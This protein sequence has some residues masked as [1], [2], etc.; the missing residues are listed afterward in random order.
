[1][2]NSL[3]QDAGYSDEFAQAFESNRDRLDALATLEGADRDAVVAWFNTKSRQFG[4]DEAD[5]DASSDFLAGYGIDRGPLLARQ[6]ARDPWGGDFAVGKQAAITE[7]LRGF[8]DAVEGAAVPEPEIWAAML[9]WFGV[10]GAALR[11]RAAFEV[12]PSS[13]RFVAPS[14]PAPPS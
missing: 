8:S 5:L 10:L 14:P 12:R 9:P 13:G 7:A 6:C 4:Y 1:V 11:R 2:Y 3:K